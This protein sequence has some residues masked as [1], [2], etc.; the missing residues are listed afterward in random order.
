[1]IEKFSLSYIYMNKNRILPYIK[2]NLL[3]KP[4]YKLRF[5][6]ARKNIF[7][8]NNERNIRDLKN[9][10]KG[11]RVFVLGNG[12]SINVN[13]INM[14]KEEITFAANKIFLMYEQTSWRPTYYCVEDDLVMQQNFDKINE[15][16]GSTKLFPADMLSYSKRVEDALYFSFI[17]KD[18]N[19]EKL[20]N[21]S[22]D[23]MKGVYWGSTIV[24]S[25]VQLAIYMGASEI[26]IL[27]VDFSFDVP[28]GH[29][30]KKKEIT[31]EG[32]VNHFHKDY[33]KKGEKWNL[34]NLDIQKK[35]FVSLRNFSDN[36]N[37]KIFNATRGGKLEV[38]VRKRYFMSYN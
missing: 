26:N 29:D 7:L 33:R 14:L 1:M 38:L 17:H 20:P 24:Y 10:Y 22:I 31:S 18:L 30:K 25:M 13:D 6:L 11:K 9:I 3:I 2:K 15:L 27:G 16:K 5:F 28:K 4:Y 36:G 35:S 37:I 8:S 32:E 23:A 12:P 34:P 19:N 21:V